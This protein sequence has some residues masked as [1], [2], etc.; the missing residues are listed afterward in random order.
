MSVLAQAVKTDIGGN[1]IQ[2]GGLCAFLS[3]RITTKIRAQDAAQDLVQETMLQA[4]LCLKDLRNEYSFRSWLYG[5]VLNVA[6]SYLRA[7][8]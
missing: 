7:K 5:I 6:Q 3:Q 4:Y 2:S 1:P 8:R